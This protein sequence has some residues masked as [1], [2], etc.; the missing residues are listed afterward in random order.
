MLTL[1]HEPVKEREYLKAL[2][3]PDMI[4]WVEQQFNEPE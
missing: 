4:V 3:A 2:K 1:V